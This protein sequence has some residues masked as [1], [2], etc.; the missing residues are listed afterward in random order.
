MNKYDKM[1]RVSSTYP[2]LD[3]VSSFQVTLGAHVCFRHR[4]FFAQRL[5]CAEINNVR[6]A[7]YLMNGCDYEGCNF[8]VKMVAYLK[9][10]LKAYFKNT[11]YRLIIRPI[12]RLSNFGE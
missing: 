11:C 12:S 5:L 2:P 6:D 9:G 7:L 8:D 10:L 3:D 1:V 4:L